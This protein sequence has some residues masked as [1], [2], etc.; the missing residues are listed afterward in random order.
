MST[1]MQPFAAMEPRSEA[2]HE[3]ARSAEPAL[4]AG[5]GPGPTSWTL[6]AIVRRAVERS[7]QVLPLAMALLRGYWYRFYFP[8]RG[9]RFRAGRYFRVAARLRVLGPGEVVIGDD[10]MILDDARLW[11]HSREARITIGSHSRLGAVDVGC[12]KEVTFGRDCMFGKCTIM[13]TDFHSTRVD[14]WSPE[15]P[16]RVLPVRIGDN[17]WVAGSVGIL[18]GTTIGANSVVGFG[19]VCQREYPAN[20]ILSG[21]PAKVISP[22]PGS[23]PPAAHPAPSGAAG[24]PH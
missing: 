17:V 8:L 12:A 20:V 15:A 16:V 6:G 19:S 1:T 24:G 23:G 14:R 4:S 22:V 2:R 3:P 5:A 7:D 9:R 10:V 18:P 13:D 11:T 21:N